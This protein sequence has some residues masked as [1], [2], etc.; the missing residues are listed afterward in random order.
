MAKEFFWHPVDEELPEKPDWYLTTIVGS[1][2]G[3]NSEPEVLV[4]RY[5]GESG[6]WDEPFLTDRCAWY[7]VV[8]WMDLPD[9]WYDERG[10]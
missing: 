1:K 9:P 2:N 10:E 7:D 8:A 3:K 5:F 6:V 4:A